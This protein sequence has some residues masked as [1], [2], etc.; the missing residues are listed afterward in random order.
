MAEIW[1]VA[2]VRRAMRRCRL[3][4]VVVSLA[5]AGTTSTVAQTQSGQ[6][7]DAGVRLDWRYDA[8]PESAGSGLG[9]L[10][11]QVREA[12]SDAPLRYPSGQ[13]AAWLQR[14][15]AALSDAEVGCRDKVK[16][17]A[18]QG[19][20]RRADIDLNAYRIVTLNDDHSVAFINPFVGLNNAK[21]ES[22][23]VLPGA[24]QAWLHLPDRL[25]LWV[26][27]VAPDR[28]LAIDTHS[29]HIVRSIDLPSG[30]FDGDAAHTS[31]VHDPD[32]DTLWL[33]LPGLQQFGGLDLKDAAAALRT[34][35]APGILAA[36][37]VATRDGT[38]VLSSHRDGRLQSWTGAM[39]GR[40]ARLNPLRTWV[41][42]A[43]PAQVSWSALADRLIVTDGSSLAW[44]EPD[45]NVGRRLPLNHPA[46]RAALFDNGRRAL[47]VGAERMSV[48]DLSTGVVQASSAAVGDVQ[49]LA[50][51]SSFAY[52]VSPALARASLWALHDL[53]AGRAQPVEVILGS[54]G[55]PSPA[56]PGAMER[57]TVSPSGTGL[58]F[59][60]AGDALVYQYAEGMM[61]PVGSYSNYKRTPL[62]MTVLDLAP[63]E[64]APGRYLATVRHERGGTFELVVSGVGPR[65]AACDRVALAAPQGAATAAEVDPAMKARLVQAEPLGAGRWRVVVALGQAAGDAA[66]DAARDA[67]GGTTLQPRSD[68]R[69]LTLLA[70]DKRSGWQHRVPLRAGDGGNYTADLWVPRPGTYEL[71]SGSISSNLDFL[72]GRLG[73]VALFEGQAVDHSAKSAVTAPSSRE[74]RSQ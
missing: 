27:T 10:E 35:S 47:V 25:T 9:R 8:L 67:G 42:S 22:M 26:R 23:V 4:A 62:A 55:A 20:G 36:H 57:T 32:S 60:N 40:D 61:A 41:L 68:L 33:P 53:R 16:L 59:A 65:F 38:L 66:P 56:V 5:W 73:S 7:E 30:A 69:D 24:P 58:L 11:L 43:P 70:F 37:A 1:L 74:G 29:R 54:A 28:L 13:I 39:A 2:L 71:M 46:S 64:V 18:T 14:K 15:R 49:S 34:V 31:F 52:A 48:V 50:F 63:R 44:L 19:I 12:G 3:A 6:V 21:L 17:L 45:G 72:Q 51:T